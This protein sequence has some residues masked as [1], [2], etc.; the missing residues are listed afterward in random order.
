EQSAMKRSQV[1]TN[2]RMQEAAAA[3]RAKADVRLGYTELRAP[4]AGV[5]DVRASRAGE[6][7]GPGQPVVTLVNPDDLW[8]RVD[9]EESYVDRI[10]LGDTLTVRRPWG[11]G[12]R[13]RVF[14]GGGDAS[15]APQRD[16]SRTRP[17]IKP[18]EWR[19]RVDT[20]ARR[21]ALGMTAYVLL[22]LP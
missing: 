21:L 18:S 1:R 6:F 8:V 17:D 7:V 2:E 3:Q 14:F 16:V 9:V 12:G 4:I 10:R 19:R 5:V 15:S 22:S 20:A 13:G 11:G